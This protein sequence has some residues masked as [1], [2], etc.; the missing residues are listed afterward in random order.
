LYLF[1]SFVNHYTKE[2]YNRGGWRKTVRI[3]G[4]KTMKKVA[5]IGLFIL[6]LSGCIWGIVC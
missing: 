1:T 4:G 3:K 2:P 6:L 5:V